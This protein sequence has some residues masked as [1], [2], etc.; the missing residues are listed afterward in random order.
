MAAPPG[1]LVT[2]PPGALVAAP[3]GALVS[4]PP[5][6]LVAAPPG[7]DR[8]NSSRATQQDPVFFP[9]PTPDSRAV[10]LRRTNPRPPQ[11]HV[12]IPCVRKR[13]PARRALTMSSSDQFQ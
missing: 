5:G 1:A 7:A 2:T 4:T 12:R 11:L 6:A 3:P 10:Y 9:S 8:G 13:K